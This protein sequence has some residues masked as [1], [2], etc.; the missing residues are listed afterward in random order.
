MLCLVTHL[1]RSEII[2]VISVLLNEIFKFFDCFWVVFQKKMII[3]K[4]IV[5][6]KLFAFFFNIEVMQQKKT[7]RNYVLHDRKKMT[8]KLLF[9]SWSF[10][11][12]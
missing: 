11:T 12:F 7:S 4:I 1:N 3:I 6:K 10:L 5:K 8:K 9:G 2:L